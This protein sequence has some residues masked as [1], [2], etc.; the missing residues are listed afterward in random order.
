MMKKEAQMNTN[1]TNNSTNQT[2]EIDMQETGENGQNIVNVQ[3]DYTLP[4][5]ISEPNITDGAP[6]VAAAWDEEHDS[7]SE[8]VDTLTTGR[9]NMALHKVERD[10]N[11]TDSD[12]NEDMYGHPNETPD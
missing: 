8:D 4:P 11:E 2:G 3:S 10:E 7:H 12:E 6:G 1:E 5:K 9:K